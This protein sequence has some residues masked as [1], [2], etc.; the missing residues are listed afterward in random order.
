MSDEIDFEKI[1]ELAHHIANDAKTREYFNML[2][3][4]PEVQISIDQ[5]YEECKEFFEQ[6]EK[7]DDES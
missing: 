7:E 2:Y 4:N 6:A 1:K 3:A 5:L